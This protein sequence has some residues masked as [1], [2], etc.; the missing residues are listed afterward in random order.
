[1]DA[2]RAAWNDPWLTRAAKHLYVYLRLETE[3]DVFLQTIDQAANELGC[4]PRTMQLHFRALESHGHIRVERT[5]RGCLNRIF[6]VYEESGNQGESKGETEGATEGESEGETKTL[7]QRGAEGETEGATEGETQG[8]SEGETSELVQRGGQGETEGETEGATEGATEGET[9]GVT[10]APPS[11]P[12]LSSPPSTPLCISSARDAR[13]AGH[14]QD[15]SHHGR[16][17]YSVDQDP[18]FVPDPLFNANDFLTRWRESGLPLPRSIHWAVHEQALAALHQQP[19]HWPREQ[20]RQA[21]DKLVADFRGPRSLS[22]AWKGGPAYLARRRPGEMQGIEK[23]L[24]WE[25]FNGAV[26]ED[27]PRLK[28]MGERVRRYS[29]AARRQKA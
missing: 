14:T 21:I 6:F 10:G 18:D 7:V 29:E 27:A 26:K 4:S 24:E 5:S 1:M 20:I 11:P 23:V 13:E 3:E 8:E 25:P 12:L 17:H 28:E 19:P 22:W 16:V 15:A 9:Q 2:I